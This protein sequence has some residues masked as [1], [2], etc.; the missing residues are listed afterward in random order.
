MLAGQHYV[1]RPT[2]G[3][4]PAN[5]SHSNVGRPTFLCWPANIFVGRP[6]FRIIMKTCETEKIFQACFVLWYSAIPCQLSRATVEGNSVRNGYLFSYL[7]YLITVYF[8][9]HKGWCRVN[10]SN[11]WSMGKKIIRKNKN[12]RV[13]VFIY[14]T[15]ESNQ[16]V[17]CYQLNSLGYSPLRLFPTI[18]SSNR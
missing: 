4:W 10:R 3:C 5:N 18:V 11:F 17:D 16:F 15:R 12:K 14:C 7:L 2:S 8:Y 1:G 9:Y 13:G 6:T